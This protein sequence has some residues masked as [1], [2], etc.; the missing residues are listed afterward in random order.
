MLS[1][2][3]VSQNV[4]Q[5]AGGDGTCVTQGGHS[6]GCS[7]PR[8][9]LRRIHPTDGWAVVLMP[10]VRVQDEFQT[11]Y[12]LY[13]MT[14]LTKGVLSTSGLM[15]RW[16]YAGRTEFPDPHGAEMGARSRTVDAFNQDFLRFLN[17]DYLTFRP[18]RCWKGQPPMLAISQR[19][20]SCHRSRAATMETITRTEPMHVSWGQ[21]GERGRPRAE[22]VECA[23]QQGA[24][25]SGGHLVA[26]PRVGGEGAAGE[27]Q[28]H[29]LPPA[30]PR[31]RDHRYPRQ[32]RAQ[33]QSYCMGG[34]GCAAALRYDVH[35]KTC[36]DAYT[37]F[38]VR[39]WSG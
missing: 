37:I 35:V 22:E 8:L 32:L 6:R 23:D 34:D 21:R 33:R 12:S 13:K 1:S 36:G 17:C 2:G 14:K 27:Q 10:P 39:Q 9:H 25:G 26:P 7:A 28:V 5:M 31:R 19:Q 4:L 3:A 18:N 24:V 30:A 38:G 16:V 15:I 11:L 29:G 20:L